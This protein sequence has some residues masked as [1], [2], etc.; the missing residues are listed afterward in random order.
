MSV[1][2][3]QENNAVHK[4]ADA[5]KRDL[6][7]AEGVQVATGDEQAPVRVDPFEAR[8]AL[9]L[10]SNAQHEA[11]SAGSRAQNPT[12][13]EL[14][15]AMEAEAR[16]EPVGQHGHHA[17]STT[18]S[19]TVSGDVSLQ[20]NGRTITVAR[21]DVERAG[22]EKLY[23]RTRELE[24]QQDDLARQAFAMNQQKEQLRI[25]HEQQERLRVEDQQRQAAARDAPATVPNSTSGQD[26]N[27]PGEGADLNTRAAELAN[28][29]YSGEVGDATR[30]IVS[31]LSD[32]QAAQRQG[33]LSAQK[34]EQ[35]ETELHQLRQPNAAQ[36]STQQQT[37]A[38]PAYE[39]VRQQI[40]KMGREE[41]PDLHGNPDAAH[42]TQNE[43]IRLSNLPANRDRRAID[44]A[45]EACD[46][47]MAK[48]GPRARAQA[49][50]QGLPVT[51]S[52]G[53]TSAAPTE[54]EVPTGS[55]AVRM[56]QQ[57]RNFGQRTS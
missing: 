22:G 10:K 50:K 26:R 41:Y 4:E 3:D 6:N 55:A 30:A 17:A 43:I 56:M 51:P 44:I 48:F 28:Q 53:G 35:L 33:Q 9:Y 47:M 5:Q 32:I 18:P 24:S 20:L 45:R 36:P 57:R 13:D 21:A 40:N 7:T 49:L 38:D 1:E 2:T 37:V 29:I 8:K 42:A 23:L 14:T 27:D 39:M 54:E 46:N 31:L 52:A 16:G 19:Q 34:A 12:V 25:E 11:E 15:L